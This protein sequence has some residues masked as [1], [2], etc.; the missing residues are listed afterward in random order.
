MDRA[1]ASDGPAEHT[2][3]SE[4]PRQDI[5]VVLHAR[6]V[7]T[8]VA[9]LA[10]AAPEVLC[11]DEACVRAVLLPVLQCSAS[12]STAVSARAVEA[13]QRLC[14]GACLA[15]HSLIPPGSSCLTQSQNDAVH[16]QAANL[17]CAANA[18]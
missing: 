3:P 13:L 4:E 12:P 5:S 17:G 2:A 15:M 7:C 18:I 11:N 1:A 10:E 6:A 14:I 9:T 8:L 16:A